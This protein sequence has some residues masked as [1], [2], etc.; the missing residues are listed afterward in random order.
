MSVSADKVPESFGVVKV[1]EDLIR[2]LAIRVI[3]D[4]GTC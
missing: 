1:I 3:V 2:G 4:F